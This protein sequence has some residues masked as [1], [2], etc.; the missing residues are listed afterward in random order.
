MADP[1]QA[2]EVKTVLLCSGKIYYDL[3]EQRENSG[4][5]D[6][7][8][9]RLEQLYPLRLDLLEQIV[10]RYPQVSDWRWVQ[11]EPANMGAW[12]FLRPQLAELLGGEPRYV[13]RPEAAA[14]AVG[15]HK[16]HKE[17]QERVVA[18]AL[19]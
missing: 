5:T 1:L 4:R 15:S 2:A 6:I 9:T 16:L 19:T 14:P 3:L 12:S 17:E 7:A 18:E 13:G 8:I 10:A 11:E